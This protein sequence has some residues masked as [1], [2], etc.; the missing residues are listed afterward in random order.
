VALHVPL[1]LF[2][3]VKRFTESKLA[4]SVANAFSGGVFLSLA[5]GHMLPHACHGFEGSGYS[6][7][8]PYYLSLT[9]Y[10][11]IFFVEKIAFDAHELLHD[12]ADGQ[13]S[14]HHGD[15]A[16]TAAA[17]DA[18]L[19]ASAAAAGKGRRANG[20]SSSAGS[21]SSVVATGNSGAA[22]A[23]KGA[24]SG[25]SAT[26]LLLAL[27]VH[28]LFETMA[29]GLSGSK[30][31][32]VLLAMSI[33]LHQPAE[34]LALLVSFLKTGMPEKSIIKMLSLFS[35]VGPLGVAAGLLIAQYAGKLVSASCC[36]LQCC[37]SSNRAATASVRLLDAYCCWLAHA[38]C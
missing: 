11:L 23:A 19:Q 34:S 24:N 5:F 2:A 13:H 6:E 10:L 32:T 9:G 7:T 27:S 20:S 25:R 12:D 17:A 16:D 3:Q 33:G 37:C 35:C 8:V 29:L 22:A 15:G 30:L 4:I 36:T 1:L 18:A 28:S 26:I 38:L 21:S 14:H 31:N